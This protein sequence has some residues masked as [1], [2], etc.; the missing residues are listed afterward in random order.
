MVKVLCMT[1]LLRSLSSEPTR[2]KSK[3]GFSTL[4]A[5]MR[6]A[7][8]RQN[9]SPAIRDVAVAVVKRV[10]LPADA[11]T[12]DATGFTT[13][14]AGFGVRV[15]G[16]GGCGLALCPFCMV[17]GFVLVGPAVVVLVLGAVAGGAAGA[18]RRVGLTSIGA[19]RLLSDLRPRELLSRRLVRT[20]VSGSLG[21]VFSL[22]RLSLSAGDEEEEE[23]E[24][25]QEAAAGWM[26]HMSCGP[27]AEAMMGK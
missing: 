19:S 2:L 14:V 11:R 4:A 10:G 17:V 15:G 5:L 21:A 8:A 18:S 26:S 25:C 27:R 24:G 13:V 20:V 6:L 23:E 16:L 7:H 12:A 3:G 22:T 9:A 1:R